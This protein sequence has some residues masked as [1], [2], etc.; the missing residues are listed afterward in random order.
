MMQLILKNKRK[1]G[2]RKFVIEKAMSGRNL[3]RGDWKDR[4]RIQSVYQLSEIL[5]RNVLLKRK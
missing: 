1:L 2:R 4:I 5:R 3:Q